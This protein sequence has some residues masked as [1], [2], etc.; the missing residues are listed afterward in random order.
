MLTIQQFILSRAK[1]LTIRS[2]GFSWVREISDI[3]KLRG[4]FETHKHIFF[5]H[6]SCL[7]ITYIEYK[8]QSLPILHRMSGL[9]SKLVES[10]TISLAGDLVGQTQDLVSQLVRQQKRTKLMS[11]M[12]TLA[13]AELSEMIKFNEE[14]NLNSQ[15]LMIDK[16]FALT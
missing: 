7:F 9:I 1:T 4:L 6:P 10:L 13:T 16:G 2:R 11:A 5:K 12:A 3:D 15:V 14:W 8:V